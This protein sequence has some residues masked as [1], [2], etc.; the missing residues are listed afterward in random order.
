ML[1]GSLQNSTIKST[2]YPKRP[3]TYTDILCCLIFTIGTIASLV[4]GFHGLT[5]GQTENILQ[6]F[7]SSGN[8]CGR[9]KLAAYKYLYFND[10]SMTEWTKE[11]VCV[12]E[13]PLEDDTKIDCYPN[14]QIKECGDL[15]SVQS[16]GFAKRFCW[17]KNQKMTE[18]AKEQFRK[19]FQQEAFGDVMD[20]W[21]V[22]LISFIFAFFVSVIYLWMLETC[23]LVIVTICIVLFMAAITVLGV[24]LYQT[25]L[26]LKTNDDPHDDDSMVYF[27]LTIL[28]FAVEFI[29]L[30]CFCCLWSRIK[31][32]ARIIE[33]TADYLTDVKRVILIPVILVI[34][35]L[36]YIMWFV[37]AGAHIFSIGTVKHDPEYPWGEIIWENGTE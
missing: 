24:A 12:A 25:H 3:R 31:L 36:A 1:D 23:A 11:N 15:K 33:A 32:A 27:Y 13:C 2:Q 35:L 4:A 16:V 6:P 22:L 28:V 37:Y 17:P 14:N 7:D 30:L 9:G 10:I 19:L 8:A 20:S 5:N 29:L 21:Q 18:T 26:G 34:V